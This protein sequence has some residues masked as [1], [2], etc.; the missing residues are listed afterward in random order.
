MKSDSYTV[1]TVP[2]EI[3]AKRR[4][5]QREA[6]RKAAQ[7][8]AE[9]GNAPAPRAEA[10]SGSE[11][12]PKSGAA[13]KPAKTPTTAS[14]ASG[15]KAPPAK[16]PKKGAAAPKT[17]AAS[18]RRRSWPVRM[19]RTLL[20][21]V[22]LAGLLFALAFVALVLFYRVAGVPAGPY[23]LAESWRL[24]GVAHEARSLD[25]LGLD[26]ARAAVA[27]E[28]ARFCAHDGLDLDAIEQ[29][30]A[31]WRRGEGMRG[32]STIT[33]QTAKNVFLWHG[34][35]LVRKALEVPVALVL[36]ALWGKRR[37]V[38]AYLNI[39]EFDEG[40]FGVEAAAR[41]Y[42]GV[43]AKDLG[44]ARAAR[45]MTVLPDPKGRHPDSP[46]LRARAGRIASGARTIEA[47]GDDAC[48]AR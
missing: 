5:R 23:M 3:A 20:R 14:K 22:M 35:T 16:A 8:A 31:E 2:P 19:L 26:V 27:A 47:R 48:F 41:H 44:P 40:V 10:T 11:A 1:S 38:E 30:I 7:K 34:R 32:A 25:D 43:A 18:G 29:A 28:D 36:E 24:G 21:R 12:A 15:R 33:Q 4:Q 6:A 13:V 46:G 37:I 17:K 45:L 9:T 42:Y 39:A